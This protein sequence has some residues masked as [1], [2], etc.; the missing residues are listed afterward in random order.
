MLNSTDAPTIRL[1]G[2]LL[3]D[4]Y[5]DNRCKPLFDKV[6]RDR[7]ALWQPGHEAARGAL[8]HIETNYHLR[9]IENKLMWGR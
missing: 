2:A 8:A 3:L 5:H 6:L 7:I 9:A 1:A 4:N